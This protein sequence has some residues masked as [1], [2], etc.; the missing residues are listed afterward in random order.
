MT[1]TPRSRRVRTLSAVAG[2]SHISVCMAGARRMG[3]RAAS[4]VLVSRLSA[5][6]A[7]I[8]AM[9]SAVAGATTM[10]SA[11][12]PWR[13]WA[14]CAASS[15]ISVWTGLPVSASQV[16]LPTMSRARGV[17]ITVTSAPASCRRRTSV[18]ALYAAMPPVTP[19]TMR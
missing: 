14:T 4:R 17:G 18:Q 19:T 1:S 9:V 11:Q 16:A 15:V 13:T 2:L 12:P 10:A 8:L 7:R 5:I 6:P 3:H